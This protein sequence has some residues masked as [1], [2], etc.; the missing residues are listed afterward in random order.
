MAQLILLRIPMC[1]HSVYCVLVFHARASFADGVENASSEAGAVGGGGS[2]PLAF[3]LFRP[4]PLKEDPTDRDRSPRST[5]E[6]F[7]VTFTS[8]LSTRYP[9]VQQNLAR[10][11]SFQ[12]NFGAI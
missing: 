2:T 9:K 4:F 3:G 8:E 7:E 10:K 11:S 1:H 12:S 6:G 5:F